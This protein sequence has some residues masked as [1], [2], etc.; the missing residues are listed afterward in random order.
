MSQ[1][2]A[3]SKRFRGHR[4]FVPVRPNHLAAGSVV[5]METGDCTIL[6]GSLAWG[7]T[8]ERKF[9]REL[10]NTLAPAQHMASLVVPCNS[11]DDI[12]VDLRRAAA[13]EDTRAAVSTLVLQCLR[14]I[15][16][17]DHAS[18]A[19]LRK[20]VLYGLQPYGG[21]IRPPPS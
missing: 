5:P 21:I 12:A 15:E 7:E 2:F 9:N 13:S 17:V 16:G 1:G 8:S 6:K 10:V 11:F 4:A 3:M 14:N 20:G 18:L 19:P